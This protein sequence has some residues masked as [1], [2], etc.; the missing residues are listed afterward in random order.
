MGES[1]GWYV[2]YLI[3]WQFTDCPRLPSRLPREICFRFWRFKLNYAFRP[4]RRDDDVAA[5]VLPARAHGA[6]Q[7]G[8]G[9]WRGGV[10][11]QAQGS[12]QCGVHRGQV[13]RADL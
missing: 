10:C 12:Q 11:V 1:R 3:A 7:T 4:F 2:G 9:R 8:G 6:G 5:V 13:L